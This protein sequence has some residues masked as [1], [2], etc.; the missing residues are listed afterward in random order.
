MWA[1]RRGAAFPAQRRVPPQPQP[2][3]ALHLA[4]PRHGPW[5]LAPLLVARTWASCSPSLRSVPGSRRGLV[6]LVDLVDLQPSARGGR[7][8]PRVA[9]QSAR[10]SDASNSRIEQP[11]LTPHHPELMSVLWAVVPAPAPRGRR[12]TRR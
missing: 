11:S 7:P 6:D 9:V 4:A 2:H 8:I 1:S 12:R 3:F 10:V 5:P